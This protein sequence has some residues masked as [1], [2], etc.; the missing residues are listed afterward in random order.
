[1]ACCRA[2]AGSDWRLPRL[3]ALLLLLLLLSSTSLISLSS[4]SITP[5]STLRTF[6][7]GAAQVQTAADVVHPPGD[8]VE[9]VV[10]QP[11]R[12]PACISRATAT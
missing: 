12:G 1:M 10:L 2:R 9:R 11:L 7:A 6:G 3:A 4:D 8:V 5:S